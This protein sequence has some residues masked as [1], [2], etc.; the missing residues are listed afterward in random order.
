M[1]WIAL[2][3]T[4]SG[5]YEFDSIEIECL[6]MD[7]TFTAIDMLNED[8]LENVE[9]G[10]DTITGDIDLSEDKILVFTIP[11]SE[12][13]TATVDGEEYPLIRTDIKYMGLD[14]TAGHH[15]IVLKYKTPYFGSGV[16][17]T[18]TGLG[19]C[20]ILYIIN[21]KKEAHNVK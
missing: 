4:E 2:A 5:K 18:V 3:F 12:G 17:C 6:P 11:Y 21:R 20:I 14:L 7:N 9:F 15:D 16:I 8:T 10:T 1:E 13:W 19:S